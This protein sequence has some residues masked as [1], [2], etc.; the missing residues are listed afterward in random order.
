LLHFSLFIINNYIIH[1]EASIAWVSFVI[2]LESDSK[3][4]RCMFHCNLYRYTKSK[5]LWTRM[6][7][8][9]DFT[10]KHLTPYNF[11]VHEDIYGISIPISEY[12]EFSGQSQMTMFDVGSECLTQTWSITITIWIMNEVIIF[13]V[14]ISIMDALQFT[15]CSMWNV[16]S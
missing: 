5:Q 4:C 10:L 8:L 12:G 2:S 7:S 14:S 1:P 15:I 6:F 16:P 9:W 3:L 13:S 11:I